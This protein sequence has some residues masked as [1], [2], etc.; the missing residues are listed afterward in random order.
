M[1]LKSRRGYCFSLRTVYYI[2]TSIHTHIHIHMYS[3]PSSSALGSSGLSQGKI[4]GEQL[5]HYLVVV[6]FA[7]A[8]LSLLGERGESR[9]IKY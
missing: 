9:A 3:D 8:P 4:M 7:L 2:Y 6:V 1:V 5:T